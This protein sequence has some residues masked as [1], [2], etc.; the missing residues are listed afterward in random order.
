MP[1]FENQIRGQLVDVVQNAQTELFRSYRQMNQQTMAEDA[2]R[3]DQPVNLSSQAT[4]S[5]EVN[6]GAFLD[7]SA[8]YAPPPMAD[9]VATFSTNYGQMFQGDPAHQDSD[10]GYVSTQTMNKPEGSE[11]GL[12]DR[13]VGA[14]EDGGVAMNMDVLESNLDWSLGVSDGDA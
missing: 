6:L 10:S 9:G 12:E 13:E 4:I 5:Q 8:F 14:F 11:A 3:G 1:S 2:A 7:F